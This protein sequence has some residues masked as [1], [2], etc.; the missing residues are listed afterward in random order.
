MKKSKQFK[1]KKVQ[2]NRVF[3]RNTSTERSKLYDQTWQIYRYRFL[4]YNKRCYAC[5]SEEKLHVDHLLPHKGD[6]DLFKKLN[7]HIP[8]CDRCHGQVTT[9]FDRFKIPRQEEKLKWLHDKRAE[10]GVVS[11]VKVL[12]R[13]GR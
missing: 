1:P 10:C 12:T 3:N 13:Y 2:G 11:S 6:V 8:L 9:L 5:G 4:H 7:N